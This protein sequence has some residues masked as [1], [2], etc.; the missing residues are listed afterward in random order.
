MQNEYVL[1]FPY[2]LIILFEGIDLNDFVALGSIIQ[3]DTDAARK[4]R[5]LYPL[6]RQYQLDFLE[7]EKVHSK[8]TKQFC[9]VEVFTMDHLAVS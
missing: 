1:Y 4:A 5:N 3:S 8:S 9:H 6:I 7:I 2:V